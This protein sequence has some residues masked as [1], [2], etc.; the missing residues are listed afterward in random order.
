MVGNEVGQRTE[1]AAKVLRN[2]L[3]RCFKHR[4]MAAAIVGPEEIAFRRESMRA[5]IV[6]IRHCETSCHMCN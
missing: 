6:A 1:A 5:L 3:T 4:H 2:L